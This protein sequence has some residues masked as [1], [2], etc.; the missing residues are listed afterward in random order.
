MFAINIKVLLFKY[1]FLQ[2]DQSSIVT[3]ALVKLNVILNISLEQN[4]QFKVK[5]EF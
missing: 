5:F 1:Y 2:L 3:V 4:V